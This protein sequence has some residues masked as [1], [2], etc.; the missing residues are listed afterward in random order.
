MV[1]ARPFALGVK[2]A[3]DTVTKTAPE[4]GR[5]ALFTGDTKVMPEGAGGGVTTAGVTITATCDETLPPLLVAV[6]T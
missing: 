5:T 1:S 4:L 6:R 3:I 2:P